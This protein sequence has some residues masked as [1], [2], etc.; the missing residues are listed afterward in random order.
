[1]DKSKQFKYSNISFRLISIL[2]FIILTTTS[3]K[4]DELS[5]IETNNNN[6]DVN[7]PLRIDD[8]IYAKFKDARD[9][10]YDGI[11]S[12]YD[13]SNYDID[14]LLANITPPE[15]EEGDSISWEPEYIET[16]DM[17]ELD[18]DQYG[19]KENIQAL[20]YQA[21]IT[22]NS[23][24]LFKYLSSVGLMSKYNSVFSGFNLQDLIDFILSQM[25]SLPPSRFESE[26]YI[27]GDI[28]L[29]YDVSSSGSSNGSSSGSNLSGW[30]TPGKYGHA[31]YLDNDK[32]SGGGNFY[33]ESASNETDEQVANPVAIGGRVGYDKVIGYWS[34]A[35]EVAVSRVQNSNPSQR[36]AAVN[37]MHQY[38]GNEWGIFNKRSTSGDFYCSKVVYR[39][40]LS[41]GIELEPHI[42]SG[43]SMPWI[44]VPAFSHW[45]YKWVWFVKVW[46]PVFHMV[47]IKDAW[48]T[49]SDLDD[50]NQTIRI[51][52]F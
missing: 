51:D 47:T 27:D 30:L 42:I 14:I 23:T 45:A 20:A 34:E 19:I 6:I 25:Q 7:K 5:A 10:F 16:E 31:A 2:L 37:S 52:A 9:A 8:D 26:E 1:M 32:R 39:G 28:F 49:P 41:Q 18:P 48:V 3:C 29:K 33:L 46:Y 21:S 15:M 44:R 40:W 22:G 13:M 11:P 35:T 50:D 12:A 43:T 4:K 36:T 24:S 38:F 17:I